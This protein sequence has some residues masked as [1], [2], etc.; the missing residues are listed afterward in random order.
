MDENDDVELLPLP[1]DDD[2]ILSSIP[3]VPDTH[4][5]KSDAHNKPSIDKNSDVLYPFYNYIP[6]I[7]IPINTY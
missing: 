5:D 6:I 2:V 3:F 4:D 1:L 7:I